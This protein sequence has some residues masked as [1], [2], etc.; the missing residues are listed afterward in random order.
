MI[1]QARIQDAKKIQVLIHNSADKG[2]MLHR[3][4]SEIYEKLRDFEVYEQDG[5]IVGVVSLHIVWEETAEIRSLTVDDSYKGNGIG[6]LLV[7][8]CL[9]TAAELGVKKVFTLSYVPE[10]FINYGFEEIDK[11]SLPHK[12]WTDCVKCHKFPDC[13]ETAVVKQLD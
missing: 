12:I 4:L 7:D 1:R 2:E 10:Y 9:D 8:W 3:P 6:K 5:N 11:H 13:D